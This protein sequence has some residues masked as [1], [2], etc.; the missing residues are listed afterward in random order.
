MF[1]LVL[2]VADLL[3]IVASASIAQSLVYG[4]ATAPSH[5]DDLF[6]LLALVLA[7]L[8]FRL[9]GV[10]R[11][12]DIGNA[13][14]STSRALC[15]WLA[16]QLAIGLISSAYPNAHLR[17]NWIASWT[18][19]AAGLILMTRYSLYAALRA[20]RSR[21]YGRIPVAIVA[22]AEEGHELAT[23][24]ESKHDAAFSLEL[25]FDTALDRDTLVADIPAVRQL[26]SFTQLVRAHRISELWIVD[27]RDERRCIERIVEAFR[28]DF[29]NIRIVPALKGHLLPE[30]AIVDCL[31]MP[32]LNVVAA[33][34]RGLRTLPKAVFD[35]L[36][37]LGALIALAPLMTAIAVTVKCSSP[38]PVFFRQYRKGMNGEVFSIYK[39][40]TMYQGA[41]RPGEITQA[42]RNDTRITRIG[43]FLRRSSLDEL[44]QFINV[45][46]GDMSVVG[47]RPHAVEHDEY[48]KNLVQHYMYRYRIKP[49][50]TGW[51]QVNGYR[52]ETERVEKMAARVRFDIH[53]IQHWTLGFDLKIIGMTLVRGFVG[54]NAY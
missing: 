41:D 14:R 49:G 32:V 4:D 13:V 8:A 31:G 18:V 23:R 15:S 20:L 12:R 6:G 34:A 21:G 1:S 29:V 10:Y 44:P 50:I 26:E 2:Q 24:L 51:A 9:F 40:R 16:A 11:S 48:Y 33:P 3:M 28:D 53:Y 22:P 5:I 42:S 37:A 25:I 39:F 7:L 54:S 43:R 36:F 19:V 35:R 30:P 17:G 52:G 27:A 38:G 46:K 45:L 47:P